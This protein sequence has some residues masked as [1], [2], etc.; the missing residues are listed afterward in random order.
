MEGGTVVIELGLS[1]IKQKFPP[2]F[3]GQYLYR[4]EE[5]FSG[6]HLFAG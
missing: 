4:D 1:Q 5:L 2:E 6:E 3:S